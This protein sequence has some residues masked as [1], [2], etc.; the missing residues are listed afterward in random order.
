MTSVDDPSE[1]IRIPVHRGFAALNRS[2]SVDPATI[3][4]E[5]DSNVKRP[6]LFGSSSIAASPLWNLT[7]IRQSVRLGQLRGPN[8]QVDD[9]SGLP[10]THRWVR[11][12]P[13]RR[14][15]IRVLF[16]HHGLLDDRTC[17]RDFDR[18][19]PF[20]ISTL[21]IWIASSD[22]AYSRTQINANSHRQ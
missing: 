7:P 9:I 15:A 8:I 21:R 17:C 19:P 4:G 6:N 11:S 20:I 18:H 12:D 14:F 10:S 13:H 16:D 5:P 2:A 3:L 1:P 22:I